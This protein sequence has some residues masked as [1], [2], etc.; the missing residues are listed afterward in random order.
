M[1]YF[2][3]L[4]QSSWNWWLS[5]FMALCAHICKISHVEVIAALI[6]THKN[7]I[8]AWVLIC[9]NCLASH[10]HP[11]PSEA[12]VVASQFSKYYQFQFLTDAI[13][14]IVNCYI[15]NWP[16]TVKFNWAHWCRPT[17]HPGSELSFDCNDN[18]VMSKCWSCRTPGLG[19]R[20]YYWLWYVLLLVILVSVVTMTILMEMV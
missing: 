2:P 10:H 11:M 18:D 1:K 16:D 13:V 7:R 12:E 9:T 14:H 17:W 8:S 20:W 4:P 3:L 19:Y 6:H 5:T 15:F